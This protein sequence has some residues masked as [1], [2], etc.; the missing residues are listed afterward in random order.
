MS[1]IPVHCPYCNTL[2]APAEYEDVGVGMQQVSPHF[3]GWCGAYEKGGLQVNRE[4]LEVEKR[5]G[6][7]IGL[8]TPFP[9]ETHFVSKERI[10]AWVEY[11]QA[12]GVTTAIGREVRMRLLERALPPDEVAEVLLRSEHAES[13]G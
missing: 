1:Y 11:I 6:W 10:N 9:P 5:R 8:V 3:C 12:S 2:C 13:I 7:I 4:M